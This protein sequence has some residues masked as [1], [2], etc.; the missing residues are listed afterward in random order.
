[1]ENEILNYKLNSDYG[2][3]LFDFQSCPQELT[4]KITLSEYRDLIASNATYECQISE[5]R[6][7]VALK[8]GEIENLNLTVARLEN[9]LAFA[10]SFENKEG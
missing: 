5:L 10:E 8:K 4:V 6:R 9:H 7:E 3:K 1:M 2:T